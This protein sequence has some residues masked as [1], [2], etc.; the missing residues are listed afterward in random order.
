[1]LSTFQYDC[2][3]YGSTSLRFSLNLRG[4]RYPVPVTLSR[5][6]YPLCSVAEEAAEAERE[7]EAEE[8]AAT[9]QSMKGCTS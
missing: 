6:C 7:R 1:M 9:S 8:M 3:G 4:T 5:P 2:W